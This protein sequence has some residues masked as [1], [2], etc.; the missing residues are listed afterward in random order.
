MVLVAVVTFRHRA[1]E[2]TPFV[3]FVFPLTIYLIGERDQSVF[4]VMIGEADERAGIS[5]SVQAANESEGNLGLPVGGLHQKRHRLR[6]RTPSRTNLLVHLP[7]GYLALP[8]AVH[9]VAPTRAL[10]L[11]KIPSLAAAV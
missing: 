2:I 9:G 1:E 5:M 8:I 11:E 10:P 6:R 4:A 3:L 7:I